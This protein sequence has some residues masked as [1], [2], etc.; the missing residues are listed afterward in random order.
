MK[1]ISLWQPWASLIVIGAKRFETRFWYTPY[2]GPILIHAAK[3]RN[4]DLIDMCECD[5]FFTE[6]RGLQSDPLPNGRNIFDALP[7][8]C[9][10]GVADL[11]ECYHTSLIDM[12]SCSNGRVVNLP[13]GDELEF[14]DFHPGRYAWQL[15]NVTRFITP[16]PYKGAQGLFNVEDNLVHDAIVKA[17]R[18]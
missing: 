12:V 7:L 5:P 13:T 9:I 18:I 10:I 14:G 11:V 16:I 3:K 2:R 6:L 8:G 1:A 15:K 17:V 4:N